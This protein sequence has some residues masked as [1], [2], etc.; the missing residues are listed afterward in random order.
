LVLFLSAEPRGALCLPVFCFAYFNHFFSFKH[1][2]F[3]D[4]P[5]SLFLNWKFPSLPLGDEGT[6]R[7]L[8]PPISR[9]SHLFVAV[10]PCIRYGLVFLLM[11]SPLA[12]SLL[13]LLQLREPFL[14]LAMA[15]PPAVYTLRTFLSL[16]I[17]GRPRCAPKVLSFDCLKKPLCGILGDPCPGR[18][19]RSLTS[20][21]PPLP[22]FIA[23]LQSEYVN[24]LPMEHRVQIPMYLI[25]FSNYRPVPPS[26]K[27]RALRYSFF[28]FFVCC[29]NG[30]LYSR[31]PMSFS[32]PNRRSLFDPPFVLL[33]VEDSLF[34]PS[35]G[36]SP[37]M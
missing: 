9:T 26:H 23:T 10:R 21:P 37:H 35:F 11:S 8:R 7:S 4:S 32:N 25:S 19:F 33:S 30:L 28:F 29:A 5:R 12:N 24:T 34:F 6:K 14:K 31:R 18:K 27:P 22:E 15:F 20:Q 36:P 3:A 2:A 17:S 13:N 16:P 1:C